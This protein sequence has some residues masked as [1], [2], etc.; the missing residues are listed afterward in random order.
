MAI[1]QLKIGIII[2]S[3]R[4]GRV[5]PQVGNW[6]KGIADQRG[7]ALYE[8]VDIANYN[9]LF[10]GDPAGERQ[11]AA[12]AKKSLVWMGSCLSLRNT[13]IALLLH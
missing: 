8:I 6:I 11:V 5:S 12:W 1:T 9:L 3:T 13:I 2:G 4:P 7:D 10:F